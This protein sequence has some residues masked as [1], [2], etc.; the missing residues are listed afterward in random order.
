MKTLLLG[1]FLPIAMAWGQGIFNPSDNADLGVIRRQ[2]TLA[3][4]TGEEQIDLIAVAERNVEHEL[5]R[6]AKF[7]ILNG[8]VAL[9]RVEMA[10]LGRSHTKK[11]EDVILRYTAIADFLEGK[12][13]QAL[14]TLSHEQLSRS[15]SYGKV[16]VMKVLSLVALKEAKLITPEWNRCKVE[17]SDELIRG[18]SSWMD[19]MVK[20]TSGA[21]EGTAAE[22]FT[23]RPIYNLSNEELKRMLKL[24]LFLNQ[25]HMVLGQIDG[26][27]FSVVQDEELRAIIAHIHF[28]TGQFARSW[29]FMED[30]ANPNVENMKGNLWLL[31]KNDQ[32]AFAQFKLALKQKSNS[33]NAAERA[34]PLAWSLGQWQEG[35]K[36]AERMY[37][38]E[39]NV[40]QQRTLASAFAVQ[41][42]NW[43]HATEKLDKVTRSMG[44]NTAQEVEQLLTYV[45][46]R[47]KD[48][49]LFRKH[50]LRSCQGGD[51]T[52]CWMLTADMN[53]DGL[54]YLVARSDE[55]EEYTPL[56]RSL[57]SGSP[58]LVDDRLIDQ[59]DID[60][61][62][63]SLIKLVK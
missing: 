16:C 18:D 35:M 3:L 30:L 33:H 40:N 38:Y 47:K 57:A 13:R 7:Y 39:G 37:I 31:R 27:D 48:I 63:D 12:W 49:K 29:K 62:D 32:I 54:A 20:L 25:E 23:R 46:L 17:N 45:A 53:W 4:H 15:P 19:V 44:D 21:P 5:L 22:Y 52:A 26:L 24:A 42:E 50:G 51:I 36:L 28:R 8:E 56:W 34:L 14:T 43:D 9:A 2:S 60:E 11:L 55:V 58:F 10:K 59:Q 1:L 41:L 61:L 6:Q